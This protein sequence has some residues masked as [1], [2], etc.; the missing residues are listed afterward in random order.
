V[1]STGT[2]PNAGPSRTRCKE[3]FLSSP[4]G[5]P[6]AEVK[7]EWS[8]TSTSPTHLHGVDEGKFNCTLRLNYVK[9]KVKVTVQQATKD[10]R[11]SRSVSLLFNLVAI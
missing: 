5:P 8:H 7:N 6:N 10:Q 9:V 3:K 4:N 2:G 11:G 1:V